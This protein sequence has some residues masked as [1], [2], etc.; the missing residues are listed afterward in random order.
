MEADAKQPLARRTGSS[1]K[2]WNIKVAFSYGPMETISQTV[3]ARNEEEASKKAFLYVSGKCLGFA[4]FL[5]NAQGSATG[6]NK[7]GPNHE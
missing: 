3:K 5:P 1:W 2:T 6:E 7:E 4:V